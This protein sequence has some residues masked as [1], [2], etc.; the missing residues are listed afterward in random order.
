MRP[1]AD[2]QVSLCQ[3]GNT[4]DCVG[5]LESAAC[6]ACETQGNCVQL[7]AGV[8]CKQLQAGMQ[9]FGVGAAHHFGLA[10]TQQSEGW[11][12]PL[13][14]T[15]RGDGWQQPI[16]SVWI[17]YS[18]VMTDLMPVTRQGRSSR[19]QHLWRGRSPLVPQISLHLQPHI[20]V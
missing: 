11:Q 1:A 16:D 4:G 8:L 17:A 20:N 15:Q 6:R 9:S 19:C 18:R 13:D 3:P 2:R 10:C 7:R 5:L 14:S 12:R